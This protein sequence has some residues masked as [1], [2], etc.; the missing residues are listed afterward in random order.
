MLVHNLPPVPT[1]LP[2]PLLL[3]IQ[4]HQLPHIAPLLR[5]HNLLRNHEIRILKLHPQIRVQ[6]PQD[7]PHV[8]QDLVFLLRRQ[9]RGDGS[10]AGQDE[11]EGE[12]LDDLAVEGEDGDVVEGGEGGEGAGRGGG[13]VAQAAVEDARRDHGV[14]FVGV[15]DLQAGAFVEGAVRPGEDAEELAGRGGGG[16]VFCAEGG[17][18]PELEEVE[19]GAEGPGVADVDAAGGEEGEGGGWGADGDDGG[20]DGGEEGGPE[21]AELELDDV[22]VWDREEAGDLV[23]EVLGGVEEEGFH[24]GGKGGGGEEAEEVFDFGE[25]GFVGVFAEVVGVFE[26]EFGEVDAAVAEEGEGGEGSEVAGGE[27][28]GFE[29][30]GGVAAEVVRGLVVDV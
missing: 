5:L 21:V 17:G 24:H 26:G 4:A 25:A 8:F 10:E 28:E 12:D 18:Q 27:G 22:G 1:T 23:A 3:I 30:G 14:V 11:E 9:L 20:A 29:G 2:Q 16:V 15:V 6:R 7:P 13:A 19:G